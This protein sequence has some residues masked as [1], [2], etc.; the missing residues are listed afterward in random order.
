MKLD[1]GAADVHIPG[2]CDTVDQ[3]LTTTVG[4]V[5]VGEVMSVAT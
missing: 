4:S 2:N 3:N 1:T 5:V